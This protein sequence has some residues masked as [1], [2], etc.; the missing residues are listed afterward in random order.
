M[1]VSRRDFCKRTL[2]A[3]AV[4]L[5]MSNSTFAAPQ[6][7]DERQVGPFICQ[8]AFPLV[9][10]E[11]LLSEMAPLEAELRRVLA[12]R[13]CKS[14]VYLHLMANEQQHNAYIAERFPEVPYR[15]ALFIKQDGRSSVFA[16]LNDELAV[17]V[18]HECTHALLHADLPMVPLWLDEGLA[19]YFEVAKPLRARQHPHLR[20]LKWDLRLG[21]IPSMVDLESKQRLEDLTARDYRFAWAWTHYMLHGPV[22]AHAE[23]V[24]FLHDI[25]TNTAPGRLSDRI[26]RAVPR[27]EQ[28]LVAHFRNL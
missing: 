25:R 26:A 10:H 9:G 2:A 23:L 12:V 16:Y 20:P 21:R 18:R 1:Q 27:V 6:W 3:G 8:A 14:P 24:T 19:E 5:S 7:I 11:P 13:P 22:A 4:A 28:H 15:R 17:D